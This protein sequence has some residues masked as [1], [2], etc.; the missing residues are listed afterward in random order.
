M[1]ALRYIEGVATLRLDESLC[2]GC[3]TCR[4][5]C[6]HAVFGHAPGKARLADPGACMEC[7]ACALNCPEGALTVS[8]G[9]GCARAIIHG[10]ITGG[11]P[12]CDCGG[13]GS[14]TCC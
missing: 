8:Q 14:S 11:P 5:V 4:E 3:G 6:P 2:T 9:V 10:W 12:S 1:N 13:D 7:G